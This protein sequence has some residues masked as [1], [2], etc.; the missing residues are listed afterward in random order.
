MNEQIISKMKNA[1]SHPNLTNCMTS[2]AQL[3]KGL[4]EEQ[5]YIVSESPLIL[6]EPINGFNQLYYFLE[7]ED[8]AE[9]CKFDAD[10][11]SAFAPLYAD[12]TLKT[13]FQFEGSVFEELGFKPFRKY[14]RKSVVNSDMKIRR[15]MDTEFAVLDDMNDILKMLNDNFDIMADHIPDEVELSE[16]IKKKQVLNISIKN[17]I[18]GTL[19]FEDTGK[20]SYAR[21][22]CVSP[23]Y[24]NSFVGYSLLA[25][26]F[27]RHDTDK[28]RL[29]YLWVDEAN[30][31]VKKLHDR[32]GYRYDGL[33]NFIF[34]R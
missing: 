13:S 2:I 19:L 4:D 18:A 5:Y 26:Y 7:T 3:E 31:N 33:N 8:L 1:Y 30:I 25:D 10:L 34:R 21:A 14:V 6:I 28:T 32:F 27:I 16:L 22:L 11:L 23:D 20:R 12:I 15:M 9:L 24:Q 17:T 29:F